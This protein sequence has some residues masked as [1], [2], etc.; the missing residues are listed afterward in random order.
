MEAEEREMANQSLIE[1][2]NST[3]SVEQMDE[4]EG[5]QKSQTSEPDQIHA[6]IELCE[7]RADS[8]SIQKNQNLEKTDSL[9]KKTTNK[10]KAQI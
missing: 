1:S 4:I 5:A 3:V 10:T 7:E 6:Q 2:T 8:L 9:P